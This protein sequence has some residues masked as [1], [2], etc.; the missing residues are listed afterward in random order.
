MISFS[1]VVGKF[2][3]YNEIIQLHI[4]NLHVIYYCSIYPHS[5]HTS[6]YNTRVAGGNLIKSDL[7]RR[8]M[9]SRSPSHV[10]EASLP[11]P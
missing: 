8:Q 11:A 3:Q 6:I 10:L 5:I 9:A 2:M 7:S 4:C 1:T